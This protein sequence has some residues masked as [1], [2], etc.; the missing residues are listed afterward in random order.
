MKG[1]AIGSDWYYRRGDI[2][3]ADLDPV[4]GSEQGGV[5][6]V[7]VVQNNRGNY[8]SPTLIVVSM[9]TQLKKP[10]LP[11]H[12][13][14]RENKGLTSPSMMHFESVHTIDKSRIRAYLGKL[15]KAQYPKLNVYLINSLGLPKFLI[16]AL[17]Y[18]RKAFP[19]HVKDPG[20]G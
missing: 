17:Y 10:D 13:L 12:Y 9:T 7:V 11:V 18:G 16:R 20:T 5:R 6:P 19:K 3:L 2:Y 4:V 1:R 15:T 14:V 8:H